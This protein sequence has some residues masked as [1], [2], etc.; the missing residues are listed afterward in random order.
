MD[1]TSPTSALGVGAL[2]V[3]VLACRPTQGARLPAYEVR[4]RPCTGTTASTGHPR[5]RTR[6]PPHHCPS[7]GS[8]WARGA[9]PGS[10]KHGRERARSPSS[11]RAL[12]ARTCD[13]HPCQGGC[14]AR[15]R[16]SNLRRG[17]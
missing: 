2:V 10:L 5:V 12:A 6:P 14:R 8:L 4:A 15:S 11:S 9:A 17:R 13:L 3:R 7:A 1:R 16:R